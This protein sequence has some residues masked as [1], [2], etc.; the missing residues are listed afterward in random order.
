M[1]KINKV[2]WIFDI[3]LYI[4]I[5]LLLTKGIYYTISPPENKIEV[6][7]VKNPVYS[8]I[9]KDNLYE[10]TIE[11]LKSKEGFCSKPTVSCDGSLTI[12]YGH[13]IKK[14]EVYSVISEEAAIKL[15]KEDLDKNIKFVENNTQLRQNKSL[16]LGCLAFN[17]GGGKLMKY[18]KHDSLL[19]GNNISRIKSY[20]NY[21]SLKGS[22]ISSK[23]LKQRREFELFIYNLYEF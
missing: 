13:V 1:N 6:I 14:N 3:I 18:I 2:L 15:L 16:A 12:G 22:L 20:C 9:D 7:T 17:I 19:F 11:H 5:T 8:H 21:R 4:A 10:F 23:A